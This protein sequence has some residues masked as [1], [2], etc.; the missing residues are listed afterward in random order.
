MNQE[1]A[2]HLEQG[3]VGLAV[4]DPAPDFTLPTH[5]E[6]ELNLAWYQGRKNV[7]LAFYPGDWTPV[8]ATQIPEYQKIFQRFEQY[9]CQLLC[10][11]VDSVPCHKAWAKSLGGLPFPLMSDFY[12]HGEISRKYGAF[13][14]RGYSD[15]V[16]FLI[17]MKG[18]IRYIERV[19][20]ARLPDNDRLFD[21]LAQLQ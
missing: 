10:I 19:D 13:I 16:V 21:Q 12:P 3:K 7:V 1:K 5:N 14:E 9:N 4:G 17:D 20:L 6:G 2:Q 15:R 8:C 11:S 18:V